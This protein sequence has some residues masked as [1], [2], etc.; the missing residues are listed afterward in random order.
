MKSKRAIFLAIICVYV[1]VCSALGISQSPMQLTQENVPQKIDSTKRLKSKVLKVI[2]TTM[3]ATP[4]PAPTKATPTKPTAASAKQKGSVAASNDSVQTALVDYQANLMTDRGDGILRLIDEVIFHHNGAI[5]Q[6][7]SAFKYDANRMDFFGKV[8]IYQ[9]STYIY[10]DR[11]NYDGRTAVADVFAPIVKTTRGE[12]TLYTYNLNFNTKTSI[13]TYYGG[14]VLRIQDKLIESQRGEYSSKINV[15]KFLDSVAMRSDNYIIRTD[16]VKYNLDAE[17]ATFL[18]TTYIWDHERDFMLASWGDYYS[19]SETYVFTREAYIMT[20]DNEL[21]ADTVRYVTPVKQAFMQTNVQILDTANNTLAF[22]EWGFYDDSLGRAVL[23]ETPSVRSWQQDSLKK[24]ADTTYMRADTIRMLTF[25]KGKSKLATADSTGGESADELMQNSLDYTDSL[26]LASDSLWN[27]KGVDSLRRTAPMVADSLIET[28]SVSLTDNINLPDTII[29]GDSLAVPDTIGL[30][31]SLPVPDSLM[32]SDSL[33]VPDTIEVRDNLPVPDTIVI[34][35][36]LAIS[37]KLATDTL[38]ITDSL[39]VPDSLMISDTLPKN[40]AA[41]STKDDRERVMRA[42][43]KVRIWSKDYQAICDSTVSF[44]V[45]STA[46]MYGKPILW[47]DNNQ[48]TSN[49]VDLYTKNE[50]MDWAEFVGEPFIVQKALQNDT[51]MFNQ[52]SGKELKVYFKN[53]EIDY[54]WL[55]GNVMNLYYMED[56]LEIVAMASITCAEL[57]IFFEAREPIRMHWAGAGEGPIHPIEKI[58]ADQPRFLEGFTWQQEV[59][60]KSAAEISSNIAR[61]S[62]RSQAEQFYQ[63]SFSIEKRIADDK[64]GFTITGLWRDRNDLIS[65]APDY[66]EQRNRNLL[67]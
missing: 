18:D 39:P 28:D 6:C 40:A 32:R 48:I 67:F 23:T 34:S 26:T 38:M 43:H 62:F 54:A 58:P 7:D 24:S 66:F 61:A 15:V 9:D 21:W 35:D 63:P 47:S 64:T 59:R 31:D 17:Q 57:T 2:D 51:L 46:V 45:D 13:G 50:Q 30:P 11:V 4:T 10:G 5:I 53:N 29:I 44:S 16:S 56:N 19:K 1:L 60:P 37:E 12:M 42:Y 27:I 55:T 49:R 8:L 65:V 14:G 41:D 33:P 36:S 52:A 25:E 3:S 20:P 22:G